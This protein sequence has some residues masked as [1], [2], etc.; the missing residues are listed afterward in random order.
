MAQLGENWTK[1]IAHDL[2]EFGKIQEI[3]QQADFYKT[4]VAG[5]KYRIFV[6]I[7]DAMRY[8]VAATLGTNYEVK[9]IA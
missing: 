1:N 4:K 8:E 5:A 6:V 9:E 7:S 3:P 2:S